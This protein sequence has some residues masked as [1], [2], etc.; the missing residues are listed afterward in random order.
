MAPPD[1]S[2]PRRLRNVPYYWAWEWPNPTSNLLTRAGASL[3][4]LC[5]TH[6]NL[7]PSSNC[8]PL[9]F[10]VSKPDIKA[11]YVAHIR[12]LPNF[13]FWEKNIRI[14][15]EAINLFIW[16]LKTFFLII[17]L[18]ANRQCLKKID[19]IYQLWFNSLAACT[20]IFSCVFLV[21]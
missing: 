20:Q 18:L 15:Q 8:K 17:Y 4:L 7:S 9:T 14:L 1:P 19:T 12:I 11:Q 10:Q 6:Q 5:M 13:F 3:V 16:F 21:I 2:T